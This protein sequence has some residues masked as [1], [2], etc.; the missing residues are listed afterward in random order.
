MSRNRSKTESSLNSLLLAA[1]KR[2]A[3]GRARPA[4]PLPG[5][6]PPSAERWGM[7]GCRAS[8]AGRAPWQRPAVA[9]RYEC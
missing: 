9:C 8:A 4:V 5:S 3:A 7:P 1:G 2:C 6:V